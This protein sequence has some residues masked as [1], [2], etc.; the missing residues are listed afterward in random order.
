MP[1][2]SESGSPCGCSKAVVLKYIYLKERKNLNEKNVN[3]TPLLI[4]IIIICNCF[5]LM[6]L[7][8][9]GH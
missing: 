3:V 5:L 2:T 8:A 6:S 1:I 9:S 7:E 4:P